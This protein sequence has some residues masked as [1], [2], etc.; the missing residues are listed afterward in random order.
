V[1]G[2]LYGE[3]AFGLGDGHTLAGAHLEQ[4]NLELGEGGEM[5]DEEVKP[6]PVRKKNSF[7]PNGGWRF[8]PHNPP[9]PMPSRG[10]G[11]KLSFERD[12]KPLF[13][14]KDR[15]LSAS[16]R[17]ERRHDVESR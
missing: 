15:G 11:D 12:I 17:A 16:R 14:T 7:I 5:V 6:L 1:S 2:D 3:L 8:A 4:V 13:R 9:E 10:E